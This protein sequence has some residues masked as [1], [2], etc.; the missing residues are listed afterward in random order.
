MNRIDLWQGQETGGDRAMDTAIGHVPRVRKP[1]YH[2][3]NAMT[4]RMQAIQQ[5]FF[6]LQVRTERPWQGTRETIQRRSK[7]L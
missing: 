7:R 1:R 5:H 2:F 6:D 3:V 4:R